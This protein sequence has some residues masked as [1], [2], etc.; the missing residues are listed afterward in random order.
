M[1]TTDQLDAMQSVINMRGETIDSQ[2]NTI[3]AQGKTIETLE[4]H[5]TLLQAK[6]RIAEC[7]AGGKFVTKEVYDKAT[8]QI[9]DRK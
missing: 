2:A 3:T 5:V 7:H 1:K 4:K 9:G 8:E 6:L